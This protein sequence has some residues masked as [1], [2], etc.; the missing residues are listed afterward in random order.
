MRTTELQIIPA[1]ACTQT[2]SRTGWSVGMCEAAS[3]S[4]REVPALCSP[5]GDAVWS[6]GLF[7]TDSSCCCPVFKWHR[8]TPARCLLVL[9]SLSLSLVLS[10]SS[11]PHSLDLFSLSLFSSLYSLL[12]PL[13]A[14]CAGVLWLLGITLCHTTRRE[15]LCGD[16]SS[17]LVTVTSV[18]KNLNGVSHSSVL[19]C[20]CVGVFCDSRHFQKV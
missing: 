17:A 4:N 11:P 19:V 14:L 9:I 7:D 6:T 2:R 8:M 1:F 3:D 15:K 12:P 10:Q 18:W 13:L 5:D 20:V 16:S